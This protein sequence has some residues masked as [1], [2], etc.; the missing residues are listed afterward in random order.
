MLTVIGLVHTPAQCKRWLVKIL[1]VKWQGWVCI[2]WHFFSII[3]QND[4]HFK[5]YIGPCQSNMFHRLKLKVK[6]CVLFAWS[7]N[8]KLWGTCRICKIPHTPRL[9]LGFGEWKKK[10]KKC[11]SLQTKSLGSLK[12][13]FHECQVKI[14]WCR[15]R[16]RETINHKQICTHAEEIIFL[17]YWQRSKGG[18]GMSRGC[19]RG[20]SPSPSASSC[21]P[22]R[23]RP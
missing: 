3:Q 21:P 20:D 4:N 15:K 22:K 10:K 11:G 5:Q 8:R 17:W 14:K 16:E 7:I 18:W 9:K 1:G 2:G 12:M 6:T 19:G 13:P 23:L